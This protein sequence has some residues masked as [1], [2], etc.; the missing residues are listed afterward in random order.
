MAGQEQR[1]RPQ[2]IPRPHPTLQPGQGLFSVP[3]FLGTALPSPNFFCS[4]VFSYNC[5]LQALCLYMP[6]FLHPF[7]LVSDFLYIKISLLPG[8]MPIVPAPL[9]AQAKGSLESR[10]SRQPGPPSKILSTRH[11][12]THY[13]HAHCLL[14]H[15]CVSLLTHTMRNGSALC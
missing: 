5:F 13:T 11:T 12:R 14:N 4:S 10:N 15:L 1:H 2:C 8:R 6:A 3:V 7:F 9:K